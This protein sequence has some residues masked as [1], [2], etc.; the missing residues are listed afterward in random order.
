MKIHTLCDALGNPIGFHLT[1]GPVH[2]LTGVDV[3]LAQ[4]P[5]KTPLIADKVYDAEARVR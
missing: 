1:P 2:D 5:P 4:V 3:L